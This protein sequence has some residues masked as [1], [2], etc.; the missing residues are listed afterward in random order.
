MIVVKECAVIIVQYEI[1]Q[2]RYAE[3]N[4]GKRDADD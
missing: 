2:S 3:E 1:M 4:Q